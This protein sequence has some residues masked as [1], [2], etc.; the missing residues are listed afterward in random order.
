M[1]VFKEME[2]EIEDARD[3]GKRNNNTVISSID[4]IN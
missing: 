1:E 4:Y 2:E 3:A